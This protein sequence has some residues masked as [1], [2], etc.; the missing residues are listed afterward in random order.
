MF[1][2]SAPNDHK[3]IYFME[4]RRFSQTALLSCLQALVI[5]LLYSYRLTPI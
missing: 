2:A 4:Y 1:K 5:V 3:I